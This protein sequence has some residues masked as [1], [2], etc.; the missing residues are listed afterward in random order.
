MATAD[1]VEVANTTGSLP[2]RFVDAIVDFPEEVL[3][4]WTEINADRMV[5]RM[6]KERG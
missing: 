5:A 3:P 6:S 1:G 2:K 4:L